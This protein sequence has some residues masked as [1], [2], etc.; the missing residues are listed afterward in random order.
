MSARSA[1]LPIMAA[2]PPAVSPAAALS[3]KPIPCP[4][5]CARVLNTP[6]K[7]SKKPIR[8]VV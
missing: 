1:G 3:L 4:E 2:R 5:F 8:A 7:V 6:M